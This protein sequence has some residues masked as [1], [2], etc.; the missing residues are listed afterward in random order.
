MNQAQL[1]GINRAYGNF[2]EFLE[3]NNNQEGFDLKAINPWLRT[4]LEWV[5][6]FGSLGDLIWDKDLIEKVFHIEKY[7]V[8]GYDG[9]K[10]IEDE[11]P[12]FILIRFEV[13][14]DNRFPRLAISRVIEV[15]RLINGWLNCCDGQKIGDPNNSASH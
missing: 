3:G 2:E 13:P 12:P 1:D 5:D 4:N 15:F 11:E 7:Q 10:F 8:V 6:T 9:E 14:L